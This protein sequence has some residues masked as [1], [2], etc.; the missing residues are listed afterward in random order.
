MPLK[1]C[2]PLCNTNDDSSTSSKMSVHK[3]P[4]DE[5]EKKAWTKAI[6]R[7]NL[8]VTKYTVVCGKHWPSSANFKSVH[9][10]LRPTEP[11]T[12]FPEIP[13]SCL[14]PPPLK[15]RKAQKALPFIYNIQADQLS[16]LSELDQLNFEIISSQ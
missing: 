11:P 10:H 13:S 12:I 9:G 14:V 15:A 2:V 6:P 16:N 4:A 3:F 7:E 5:S 8:L 1:R